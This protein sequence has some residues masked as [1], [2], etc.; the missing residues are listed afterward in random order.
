MGVLGVALLWLLR[1]WGLTVISGAVLAVASGAV[2]LLAVWAYAEGWAGWLLVDGS[3]S[4]YLAGVSMLYLPAI[5]A[6]M[7]FDAARLSNLLSRL[8]LT[9]LTASTLSYAAWAYTGNDALALALMVAVLHLGLTR[10]AIRLAA[11]A[12]QVLDRL[13]DPDLDRKALEEW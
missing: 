6:V 13:W 12:G 8:L 5:A 7:P 4:A 9:L 11:R 3:L 2:L 1:V 10:P